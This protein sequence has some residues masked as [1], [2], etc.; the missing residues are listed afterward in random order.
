MR[1]GHKLLTVA[2]WSEEKNESV[3]NGYFDGSTLL[4]LFHLDDPG[5]NK[6]LNLALN[7]W[8]LHLFLC[9]ARILHKIGHYLFR[10]KKGFTLSMRH[11]NPDPQT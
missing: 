8:V 6:L 4:R 9:C 1:I 3:K 11:T 2:S 10:E 5:A 7:H